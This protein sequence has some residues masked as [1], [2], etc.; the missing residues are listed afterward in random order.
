MWTFSI[1][2]ESVAIL[3]QLF[4]VNNLVSKTGEAENFILHYLSVMGCYRAFYLLNWIYRYHAE[5]HIDIIAT[6]AGITQTV[7]Y[8]DFFLLNFTKSMFCKC[9]RYNLYVI[10]MKSLKILKVMTEL[11][12]DPFNQSK[13][14]PVHSKY[15]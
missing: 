5:D 10:T 1:Y 14:Q 15:I 11:Y 12:W 6:V 4:L 7:F 2:L 13:N 3:P 8:L 9:P